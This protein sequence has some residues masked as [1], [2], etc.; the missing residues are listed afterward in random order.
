MAKRLDS[1]YCSPQC[2]KNAWSIKQL[3][4]GQI[5]YTNGTWQ[6]E[7]AQ[8]KTSKATY[9]PI[10]EQAYNLCGERKSYNRVVF[11]DM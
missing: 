10:S 5:I 7:F 8:Q 9:L 11:E 4:C 6:V 1:V 3:K 2:S